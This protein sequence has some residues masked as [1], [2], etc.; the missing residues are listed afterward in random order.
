MGQKLV[1]VPCPDGSRRTVDLNDPVNWSET[2]AAGS[3][4]EAIF[5][6]IIVVFLV[7]DFIVSPRK[8]K[9][10]TAES[11][12]YSNVVSAVSGATVGFYGISN[13]VPVGPP[14]RL[15]TN[16]WRPLTLTP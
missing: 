8:P 16:M 2:G 9:P 7:V 10:A 1:K 15:T 11:P 4:A 12:R 5:M 3:D 13:G 6:A 14:L